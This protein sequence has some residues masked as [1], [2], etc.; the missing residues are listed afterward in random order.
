M[1]IVKVP[2]IGYESNCFLMINENSGIFAVVDPSPALERIEETMQKN[3]LS[4]E[5]FKYVL[6]THG[7]FD[8]IY[9]VDDVRAKYGCKVCIHKS[10][11]DY[12]TDS[13]K[14]ANKLFFGEDLIMGAADVLL[15]GGDKIALGDETVT[16]ISTP[17]HTPGCVCYLI[18]DDL[19]TGDTLFDMSIG[20]SDLPGGDGRVLMD[21]LKMLSALD[22]SIKIYPGHG[23]ISTIGKQKRSNPYMK[24]L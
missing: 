12:L 4:G 18:G 22:E 10:D 2:S 1:K 20:R 5:N 3:G 7:H 24:G 21:S 13:I 6:L 8:H 14:N 16:V 19:I 15:C 17:G 23:S 9:S 11:A